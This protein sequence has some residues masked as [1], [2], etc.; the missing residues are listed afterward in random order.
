MP[1]RESAKADFGPLLPR[2]Q[3][4]VKPSPPAPEFYITPHNGGGHGDRSPWPPSLVTNPRGSYFV[5]TT[6]RWIALPTTDEGLR[7]GPRERGDSRSST[8]RSRSRW[9][10]SKPPSYGSSSDRPSSEKS[11]EGTRS[12]EGGP[13]GTIVPV[14]V[15]CRLKVWF[16]VFDA[17]KGMAT[18]SAPVTPPGKQSAAPPAPRI[19]CTEPPTAIVCTVHPPATVPL[20][21]WM[22][23]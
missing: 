2:F 1:S 15:T 8:S 11:P 5:R 7:R 23:R 4:P 12:G 22:K 16:S 18:Y 9:R 10:D 20:P 17:W 19:T 13:D 3:P 14:T 21:A 6:V